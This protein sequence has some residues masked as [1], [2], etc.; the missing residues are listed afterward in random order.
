M[1]M[2]PHFLTGMAIATVVPE[3]WPASVMAVM[4]HLILDAIPHKDSIGE[5][6]LNKPNITIR[7]IDVFIMVLFFW[8][9]TKDRGDWLYLLLI[10]FVAVLPDWLAFP[11]LIWPKL[12]DYPVI[13]DLHQWHSKVIQHKNRYV[14]WFWGLLP[15]II[16]VGAMIWFIVRT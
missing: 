11:Y 14:N 4:S 2:T 8:Y 12:Y 6:K 10:G 9:L 16:V 15:Q 5:I 13:K 1:L 7:S 3:V